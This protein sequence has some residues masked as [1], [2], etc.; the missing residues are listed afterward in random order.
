MDLK[1][2]TEMFSDKSALNLNK[3]KYK[4]GEENFIGYMDTLNKTFYYRLTL[5]DFSGNALVLLP[6]GIN[7]T[8]L[9]LLEF[10]GVYFTL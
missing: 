2:F 10:E 6:V 8:T 9:E 4:Y 1:T 7:L 5:S 3:L